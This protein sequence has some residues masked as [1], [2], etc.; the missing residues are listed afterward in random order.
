MLVTVRD[1]G[2]GLDQ[3][4]LDRIFDPF[5]TTKATGMGIGLNICET[6]VQHHG[7]RLWAE[8]NPEG[9]LSM[10]MRLPVESGDEPTA[11]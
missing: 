1:N 2:P 7:G 6:I 10:H 8:N 3:P 11:T 5:F 4:T 9:G